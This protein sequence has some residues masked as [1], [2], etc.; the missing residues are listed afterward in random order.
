MY[1]SVAF[2]YQQGK[3]K[4]FAQMPP[5]EDRM[6]PATIIQV[7]ETLADKLPAGVEI[8]N[9]GTFTNAKG[10][11]FKAT[12]ENNSLEI[13]F[14]VSQD[15]KYVVFARVW[16]RGDSGVFDFYLNGTLFVKDEDLFKEHHFATDL[17]IGSM[18]QL[19]KGSHV[20]KAVSKGTGKR[21]GAAQLFFDAIVLEKLPAFEVK[22]VAE[23]K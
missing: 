13:P 22:P 1:S 14:E 21:G 9:E 7:D 4:R 8:M 17:K 16:P 20:L 2:W 19:S 11:L 3:A 10:L 5:V 15:G 18:H 12:Q 6:I 23:Q